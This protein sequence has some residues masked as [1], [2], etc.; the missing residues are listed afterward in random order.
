MPSAPGRLYEGRLWG[1]EDTIRAQLPTQPD[2]VHLV[3]ERFT[4]GRRL[5][6]RLWLSAG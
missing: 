5:G 2:R 4:G 1:L 3:L 6:N